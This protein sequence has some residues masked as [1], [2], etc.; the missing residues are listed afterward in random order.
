MDGLQ[1][2]KLGGG[3]DVHWKRWRLV[4]NDSV[5]DRRTEDGM[6]E[7]SPFQ[8]MHIK[9]ETSCHLVL[10]AVEFWSSNDAKTVRL[11]W[12]S[13]GSQFLTV[14]VISAFPTVDGGG[15]TKS[16]NTSGGRLLA[17]GSNLGVRQF[18]FAIACASSSL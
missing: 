15:T 1:A 8:R 14:T 6:I 17:K 5:Y 9:F 13:F 7:A 4:R 12:S 10:L 3:G 2:I 16:S 11:H 18:F